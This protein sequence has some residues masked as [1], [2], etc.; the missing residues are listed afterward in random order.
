M[1]IETEK[2]QGM[3]CDLRDD[4]GKIIEAEQEC[5]GAWYAV[6][7]GNLAAEEYY[8]VDR[9]AACI[10]D[11]A[12]AYGSPLPHH[13]ELLSYCID[14]H[15][16]GAGI[17]HYEVLRYLMKN[18]L[19]LP[20][21][22]TLLTVAVFGMEDYPDYF[23]SW[24][25]PRLTPRGF[26]TRW[27]ELR[28]GVFSIET[29]QGETLLAVCYPLWTSCLPEPIRQ[30]AEQTDFDRAQGI[31]NTLGYLFFPEAAAQL[32]LEELSKG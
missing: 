6:A 13:P 7:D 12:K 4:I 14:D 22:E 28:P 17:V 3:P 19:P 27:K 9:E 24:P 32:V 5:P 26:T 31:D 15:R 20:E 11:E 25:A 1:V 18:D 16:S 29:D 10:S 23:G 8:I 21:G 30:L 2:P